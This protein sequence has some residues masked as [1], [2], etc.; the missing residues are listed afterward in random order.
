MI[1]TEE[2]AHDVAVR[3]FYELLGR[4]WV[5][6]AVTTTERV[7][8]PAGQ[9]W[10]SLEGRPVIS[11]DSVTLKRAGNPDIEF[12]YVLENSYHLRLSR[13]IP[14]SLSAACFESPQAVE[15]TY[16]YGAKPPV[17]MAAAIDDLAK[18]IYLSYTDSG[19]CSLPD[20]VT[21]VSRQGL[22]MQLLAATELF[23][24]GLTGVSTVDRVLNRYNPTA[25][26]RKA[27]V[28]SFNKPPPRRRNTTQAG[29]PGS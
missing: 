17:D 2:Q 12:D 6:P 25:T 3:I 26:R 21:S 10:I 24:K 16:T 7:E 22:S 5:W 4:R 28:F 1:I 20:T 8:I 19:E 14:H 29:W 13:A 11:I 27:R 23:E 18:E 9:N 15:I